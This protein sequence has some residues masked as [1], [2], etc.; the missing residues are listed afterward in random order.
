MSDSADYLQGFGGSARG[1]GNKHKKRRQKQRESFYPFLVETSR[2]RVIGFQSVKPLFKI[3]ELSA[4]VKGL[5]QK[6]QNFPLSAGAPQFGQN[7]GAFFSFGAE[8][9]DIA[10]ASSISFCIL[11]LSSSISFFALS[12]AASRSSGVILSSI[13]CCSL[14][15]FSI[16][17]SSSSR[18]MSA[19]SFFSFYHVFAAFAHPSAWS[20]FSL[21]MIPLSIFTQSKRLF[22]LTNDDEASQ[23]IRSFLADVGVFVK[24][25]PL[26]FF[27]SRILQSVFLRK[28]RFVKTKLSSPVE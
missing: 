12:S 26:S 15:A 7:P 8:A 23:G 4:V 24:I 2:L 1:N 21:S 25:I 28:S 19:I 10:A 27:Y 13:A 17:F 16:I 20:R 14:F 9:A 5:P 6:E 22:S 11:A 3:H 18:L